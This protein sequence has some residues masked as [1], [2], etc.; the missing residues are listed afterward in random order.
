M[1]REERDKKR[2][3]MVAAVNACPVTVERAREIR[4]MYKYSGTLCLLP[5]GTV[6]KFEPC[7]E[8]ERLEINKVWD[9]LG[10]LESGGCFDW[11]VEDLIRYKSL[12][13]E[14]QQT[15]LEYECERSEKFHQEQR[16]R[17][18]AEYSRFYGGVS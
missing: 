4:A 7:S 11:A 17:R 5:D 14:D 18:R 9:C 2:A 10:Y 12:S 13:P 15:L 1:Q 16:E 8:A 3:E 6:P